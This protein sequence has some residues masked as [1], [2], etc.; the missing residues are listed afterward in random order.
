MISQ[1]GRLGLSNST[2]LS[3]CNCLLIIVHYYSHLSTLFCS[4]QQS[5]LVFKCWSLQAK[6]HL[7][8]LASALPSVAGMRSRC[9]RGWKTPVLLLGCKHYSRP[10]NPAESWRGTRKENTPQTLDNILYLHGNSDQEAWFNCSVLH[11]KHSRASNHASGTMLFLQCKC[12]TGS[13]SPGN[14]NTLRSGLSHRQYQDHHCYS[15]PVSFMLF[16]EH[17][18]GILCVSRIAD[19]N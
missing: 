14:A 16:L 7:L 4:H 12:S 10:K 9:L 13:L 15:S 17:F 19:Q 8:W 11:S 1:L 2:K 5:H 6:H 18:H 3:L